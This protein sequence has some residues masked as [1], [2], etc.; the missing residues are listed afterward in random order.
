MTVR[1]AHKTIGL[2][3]GSFNPAHDGHRYISLQALKLLQLDEIWWLVSPLNPLKEASGMASYERRMASA[4]A[5]ARHPKI[6]VSSIEKEIHTRYTADTIEKLQKLYPDVNFVWLMGA[7]NLVS[8]HR[9]D[10]W[11]TIMHSVPIAVFARKNYALRALHGKA[12]R[13]YHLYR[14]LPEDAPM[15]ARMKPPAWMFLPIRRHPASA[16][17]IRNKG[18]FET[19]D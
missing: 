19:G 1:Y 9:W 8:F 3:G 16:T 13:M 12:A 4:Q 15:L 18:L 11:R 6:R 5:V 17:E 14:R 7:D 2:L 10:H